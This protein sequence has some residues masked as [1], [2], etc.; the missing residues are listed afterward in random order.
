MSFVE[1]ASAGFGAVWDDHVASV[2]PGVL[3]L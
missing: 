3:D 2:M 1:D